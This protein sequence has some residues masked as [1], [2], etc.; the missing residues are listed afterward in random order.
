MNWLIFAATAAQQNVPAAGGN[1]FWIMMIGM[2]VLFW[3]FTIVPQRKQQ[4]QRAA[5]LNGLKKGDKIITSGGMHGEI[6]ELD[7]EDIKVRVADKVEIKIL[8][9]SVARVKD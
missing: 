3:V 6:V 9:A 2:L 5:M 7:D 1:V 8:K 4:K